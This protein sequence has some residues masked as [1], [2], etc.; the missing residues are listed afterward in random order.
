MSRKRSID[1][2]V[3]MEYRRRDFSFAKISEAMD[4]PERTLQRR[5]QE[6][7]AL[8]DAMRREAEDE[9]KRDLLR[10]GPKAKQES[11]V[12]AFTLELHADPDLFIDN[13]A[14]NGI[15]NADKSLLK[16]G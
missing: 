7:C 2:G 5:F 12:V 11:F 14:T 15:W 9:E 16:T 4:I 1:M 6:Y 8:M 10:N 13:T 3:V